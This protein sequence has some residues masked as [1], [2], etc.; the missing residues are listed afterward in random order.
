MK[1]IF[2]GT[3]AFAVPT[4]N[5]LI[6]HHE[7]LA[8]LTRPDR[9]AGRGFKLTP[10][11]I[12]EVALTHGV[13]VLQPPTLKLSESKEIRTQLKNFGADIFVVAAYGLILPKGVRE[14]PPM[15]CINVHASLLPKYRGASPIHAAILNGET[16]TGITIMHME[17]GIDTGDMIIKKSAAIGENERFPELHDRMAELGG[18]LIIEALELFENGTAPRIPQDESLSCYAPMIQKQDGLINWNLTTREIINKIRAL[19]PWPGCFTNYQGQVI[20]IWGAEATEWTSADSDSVACGTILAADSAAGII[21]KTADGFAKVTE[22]QPP[23]GKKMP[24]TDFLRGRKFM[25]QGKHL[26][27]EPQATSL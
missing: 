20:K 18:E 19:D 12:K 3:P 17:A 22:L 15:G 13:P 16:E 10:S 2:M 6:K 9:P 4:L 8:V 14:M 1:V 21:I 5:A 27:H 7:V 24:A 26:G 25:E 11:P 23:G